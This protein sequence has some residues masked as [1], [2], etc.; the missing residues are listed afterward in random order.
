MESNFLFHSE[1]RKIL[2]DI[3]KQK[4]DKLDLNDDLFS[5]GILDSFA[6]IEF[7]GAL[8]KYFNCIIPQEDLIPQNLWSIQAV[9]EMLIKLRVNPTSC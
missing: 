5:I 2:S 6:T 7:V 1:I 4:C 9:S 8:E 3:S